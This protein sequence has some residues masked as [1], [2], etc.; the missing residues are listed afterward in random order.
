MMMV[1]R[2][3][4]KVA[5]REREREKIKLFSASFFVILHHVPRPPYFTRKKRVHNKLYRFFFATGFYA[6]AN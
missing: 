6:A 2:W 3:R 5:K 1:V 4:G